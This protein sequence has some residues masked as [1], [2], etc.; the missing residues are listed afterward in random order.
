M[1]TRKY[2]LVLVTMLLLSGTD[3]SSI[4]LLKI[5]GV[6]ESKGQLMIAVYNSEQDFPKHDKSHLRI[7]YNLKNW[8]KESITI[9]GLR[10]GHTYALAIY[11]DENE[12]N[13]LDKNMFGLPLEK[14]AFSN[15]ARGTFG[16]PSFKESSFK[17]DSK[18][19]KQFQ[20]LK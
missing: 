1:R 2:L 5:G 7:V 20:I 17:Q 15:N 6:T 18:I 14:Y 8:K 12:N 19:K 13:K 3:D 10:V 9:K 16:P 4:M 11:H